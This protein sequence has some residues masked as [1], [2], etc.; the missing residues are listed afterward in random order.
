MAVEQIF[1]VAGVGFETMDHS[2][3][4]I[5]LLQH[6]AFETTTWKIAVIYLISILVVLGFLSVLLS[7][8][9]S[10]RQPPSKVEATI[11]RSNSKNSF[12]KSF[13]SPTRLSRLEPFTLVGSPR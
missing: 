12:Q 2:A 9:E 1:F 4:E 13:S 11:R 7:P 8:Q 5:Y 10:K 6:I 3:K